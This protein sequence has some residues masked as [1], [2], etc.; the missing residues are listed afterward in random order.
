MGGISRILC[1]L[2]VSMFFCLPTFAI[3]EAE[4]EIIPSNGGQV[5]DCI[6]VLLD[7]SGSMN[8]SMGGDVSASRMDAAKHILEQ[9]IRQAPSETYIGFLVMSG[10]RRYEWIQKLGP[11]NREALLQSLQAIVPDHS[12]PL[13]TFM[14]AAADELL[15]MREAQHNE[16]MYTLLVLTDGQANPQREEEMVERF[17]PEIR[18]RGI[19]IHAVGIDMDTEHTLATQADT[20]QNANNAQALEERVR[21]VFAEV[22]SASDPQL[23]ADA[24]L[25][26]APLSTDV[27]MAIVKGLGTSV[28]GNHPIGEDP[29]KTVDQADASAQPS[30]EAVEADGLAPKWIFLGLIIVSLVIIVLVWRILEG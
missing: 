1:L 7:A 28:R 6:V 11:S 10:A 4:G 17:T 24:Y 29:P 23:A 20:Y 13:G 27:A 19:L 5:H 3:T 21:Q 9:A 16:G 8:E 26:I 25:T 22:S 30:A 15:R 12:T 2:F 14:K 18:S